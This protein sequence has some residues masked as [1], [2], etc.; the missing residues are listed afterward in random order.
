[1]RRSL[2]MAACAKKRK[3]EEALRILDQMGRSKNEKGVFPDT[4]AF[5]S[6]ISASAKAAKW[7]VALSLLQQ[8]HR[9]H[10]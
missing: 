2:A 9:L 8:M 10:R 5:N 1:M 7:E 6:A 3:W 4:V